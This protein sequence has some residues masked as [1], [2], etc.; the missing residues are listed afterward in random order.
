MASANP[1]VQRRARNVVIIGIG[2]VVLVLVMIPI[3]IAQGA[4]PAG[5]LILGGASVIFVAAVALARSGRVALGAS[6]LI[7]VTLCGNLAILVLDPST[8]SLP[9]FLVLSILLATVLLPPIQIWSVLTVCLLGNAFAASLFAPERRADEIWSEAV[10]N[11]SLLM[12]AVAVIGYLSASGVR[13][14]LV[15]AEAA[16]DEAEAARKALQSANA[17]LEQRVEER[18]VALRQIADEH[19]AAA[20]EL[21][22]SLDAQQELNRIVADLAVPVIPVSASTL[23]VPLVGNIDGSRAD[24]VLGAVLGHVERAG[25]RTVVLDVT[26]VAVVDTHVAAT[27]LQVAHATRLMGAETVL[28]GIRPEVAQALV[29][30]GADLRNLRTVA[31]LQEAL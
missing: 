9:F 22:A 11:S 18:T 16:R 15:Q 21:R 19:R 12:V 28:A 7:G 13:A 31:T 26:G 5:P 24:Q 17:S 23:V 25:A 1:D 4:P 29:G 27:L 10:V 20:A 30:L 2:L 8:P 3:A 14:A 6:L